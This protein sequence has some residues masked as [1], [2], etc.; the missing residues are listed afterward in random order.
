MVIFALLG[1]PQYPVFEKCGPECHM[2]GVSFYQKC[3]GKHD[4]LNLANSR[5][6]QFMFPKYL[7][8]Y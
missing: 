5:A 3:H 4:F 7:I 1:H 6:S 8:E 2:Q